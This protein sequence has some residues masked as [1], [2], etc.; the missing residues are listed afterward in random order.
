M[1]K[2]LTL[3]L[4]V[5]MFLT[6]SAFIACGGGGTTESS[7]GGEV[8]P[9][10]VDSAS[11]TQ[12]NSSSQ[13]KP[14]SSSSLPKPDSSSSS[15]KPDSSSSIGGD[16]PSITP[17]N[18]IEEVKYLIDKSPDGV[19]VC[20]EGIVV[21]FDSMGYAHVGD[22]SGI[23]YVRAKHENLSLASLIFWLGAGSV[24]YIPLSCI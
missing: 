4:A 7:N 18:S 11:S 15:A 2:F 13:A 9:P 6:I 1:K 14:D 16:E 12:P 22:E 21:G 23:I 24:L 10:V 5:V 20:F 17:L 19:D 3:A 8:N